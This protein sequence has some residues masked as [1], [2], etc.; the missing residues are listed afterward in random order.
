MR[1]SKD[2]RRYLRRVEHASQIS[3][4]SGNPADIRV[5]LAGLSCNAFDFPPTA[6]AFTPF[7]RSGMR[8]IEPSI[9]VSRRMVR[10]PQSAAALASLMT[11]KTLICYRLCFTQVFQT[12]MTRKFNTQLI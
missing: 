1:I 10:S 4:F 8:A 9:P 3:E 7:G 5:F 2:L 12:L 6:F 11:L